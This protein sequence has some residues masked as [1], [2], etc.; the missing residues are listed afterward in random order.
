MENEDV[1]KLVELT[2]LQNFG[3]TEPVILK[4]SSSENR[5][6]TWIKSLWEYTP[7][8]EVFKHLPLL[9]NIVKGNWDDGTW[10]HGELHLY[11]LN[12]R[13][14]KKSSVGADDA[15][16][17]VCKAFEHLSVTVL[18]SLPTWVNTKT[19]CCVFYP[20]KCSLLNL[21]DAL[22]YTGHVDN[23]NRKIQNS[24]RKI[25]VDFLA[26]CSAMITER[27]ITL[28]HK[29]QLFEE[30][31]SMVSTDVKFVSLDENKKVA[32][33]PDDFPVAFPEPYL[34]ISSSNHHAL[35]KAL[36]AQIIHEKCVVKSVLQ[37]VRR[38][39]YG[40]SD[41]TKFMEW[42]CSNI[43]RFLQEK[44]LIC[45]A[46][47][48]GFVKC[49][50][51]DTLLK[52]SELFDP[53]E[54]KLKTLFYGVDVFPTVEFDMVALK[55]LGL[56]QVVD[57]TAKDILAIAT[58]LNQ[59]QQQG[60]VTEPF[61]EKAGAL[62][63]FLE[64]NTK[65]L[66]MPVDDT[67]VPLYSAISCLSC[68]P[69]IIKI[70]RGYPNFLPWKG[71]ETT[72]SSPVEVKCE[73]FSNCAGASITLIQFSSEKLGEIYKWNEAPKAAT[74]IAQLKAVVSVYNGERKPE[75]LPIVTEVYKFMA[76]EDSIMFECE[77]YKDLFKTSC[78]WWGDGFCHPAEIVIEKGDGDIDL[79]PYVRHLPTELWPY[80]MFLSKIGC[81][82][83]QGTEVFLDVQ[84][85]VMEK[86]NEEEKYKNEIGKD[87][88][89]IIRILERLHLEG[90]K[91]ERL[92]FP[93]HSDN[94]ETLIFKPVS[95][96]SY[97]DSK[98]LQDMAADEEENIYIVH[99]DVPQHVAEGLGVKSLRQHL[100]SDADP[101]G[102]WGQEEPL[103]RRLHSLLD[104]YRD[105]LSVPKELIQ[106][107]DDAGATKICF[108]YDEREHLEYRTHLL[109]QGMAD[110][111]G[112][113]LFVYNNARFSEE[114][115]KN[116]TKLNGGTKESDETKIGKFGL[117]FC[118]VY[119]LTDVPS[120][121]SGHDFV[122][123]DP[124]KSHLGRA[125]CGNSPGLRINLRSLKNMKMLKRLHDQFKPFDG[126]LGCD[127]SQKS[128]FFD[129]TLFRF[130]LR[131]TASEIKKECYTRDE[132]VRLIDKF[133]ASI[134]D[135]LLFTQTIESI[136]IFHIPATC[137]DP[138]DAVLMSSAEREIKE[139]NVNATVLQM[140]SDKK[141]KGLLEKQPFRS[142]QRSRIKVKI[143]A[144]QNNEGIDEYSE[145]NWLVSW[146]TGM[147]ESLR[148]C[149]S[150]KQKGALPLGAV[151]ILVNENEAFISVSS[152][153]DAP[154]GF[155]KT[156][157][158]FCYLPLPK[159]TLFSAHINGSFAVSSDRRELRTNNED[160]TSA[161][162]T[163]WN[164][165]IMSDAVVQA[166]INLLVSMHEP[167]GKSHKLSTDYKFYQL[168]PVAEDP[169]T[170]KLKSGFY[171][172][173]V[174]YNSPVFKCE[175]N[176][177]GLQSC[178]FLEK[179]LAYDEEIGRAAVS[180]LKKFCSTRNQYVID[181]P[182]EYFEEIENVSGWND[183]CQ[184]VTIKEFFGKFF[185][186]NINSTYWTTESTVQS[187]NK[188][189]LYCICLSDN[190]LDKCLMSIECV[191]TIPHGRKRKPVDL[192]HLGGKVSQLFSPE[193]ERFSEEVFQTPTTIVKLLKLGMMKDT[194]DD[195]VLI[196]RANTVSKLASDE[197]LQDA[198]QRCKHILEYLKICNEINTSVKQQLQEIP[199][200]PVQAKPR[201]WPFC[202]KA[203]HDSSHILLEK[204]VNLFRSKCKELVGCQK[205]VLNESD[206]HH[207][208]N[209]FSMLGVKTKA[210][211]L[212]DTVL[213]QLLL[214]CLD[215]N[216]QLD[217][218][219]ECDRVIG[220][221]FQFLEKSVKEIPDARIR[222][223]SDLSDKP[224]LFLG[225]RFVHASNVA[226][227]MG[228][229]CTPEL[230]AVEQSK[231]DRYPNFL[232]ALGVEEHFAIGTVVKVI[233]EKHVQFCEIPLSDQA[234]KLIC[235]LL[236][237]LTDRMVQTGMT[238]EDLLSYGKDNIVAPDSD[239]ILRP[240]DQLCFDDCE[241]VSTSSLMKFVH[242]DLSRT[243]SERLG[244]FTKRRKC[245]E[246]CS[247][248]IPFEQ[249]E[250][251][252]TRLRGL[253]DGYPC[254][255]GIMK[256]LI[257]NADDA[258]ATDI[259]FM[260]D[261]RTHGCKRIF[262]ESFS[263]FQGPA[264]C[265]YNDSSFSKADLL[266]I[267]NLGA[268]SKSADPCKT[269]QYGVG[270][271]AVYNLT[272][273]PS[274]LTK[275]PDIEGGETLCIFDPLHKHCKRKVGVR[276][277]NMQ[278][279]RST[280]SDVVSGYNEA[281]LFAERQYGTVFRLPLRQT[282]SGI[283]D[284][285]ITRETLTEVLEEFQSEM[286]E[287]MLFL[288]SVSTITVSDITSGQ[289][290]ILYSVTT[291]LTDRD[292][293]ERSKFIA[294]RSEVG[295]NLKT[296]E[297]N[298]LSIEPFEAKYEMHTKDNNDREENWFVVQ[299]MGFLT[300]NFSEDI[301]KAVDKRKIGLLPQGGVAVQV[302]A[303]RKKTSEKPGHS[304]SERFNGRAYCFLPLP[305]RTGMPMHVN[306]HFVLDHEAR[307]SL[308]KED[309]GFKSDWNLLLLS[310]VVAASY[311]EALKFVQQK[312]SL[313]QR[314]SKQANVFQTIR[315]LEMFFPDLDETSEKYWKHLVK[316]IFETVVTNHEKL[317]P[318]VVKITKAELVWHAFHENGHKFSVLFTGDDS[319]F[320]TANPLHNRL[321]SLGMKISST[322]KAV[323]RTIKGAGC[324]Y[325]ILTP[326]AVV[327]FLKS[328]DCAEPDKVRLDTIPC[329]VD[330]TAYGTVAYVVKVLNYCSDDTRFE[331][332]LQSLPLLVT[333]DGVLRC[334]DTGQKVFCSEFCDLLKNSTD[335]FV[336]S[337][338][339][340]AIQA[341]GVNL[342]CG[343]V[344]DLYLGDFA[345]LL[346]GEDSKFQ[347]MNQDFVPWSPKDSSVPDQ[348]WITRFWIF[349]TRAFRMLNN[350]QTFIEYLSPIVDLC[351]LPAVQDERDNILMK[352][353]AMSSVIH[354]ETFKGLP[355]LYNALEH[356]GIPRL[357]LN[358]ISRRSLEPIS[359]CL[360]SVTNP[361]LLLKCLNRFR[362]RLSG[363]PLQSSDCQAI[364]Q[365]FSDNWLNMQT[366]EAFIRIK[367]Y[368]CSLP[369]FMTKSGG[370][371]SL[372]GAGQTFF[373]LPKTVP[374]S[375]LNEWCQRTN[376]VLIEDIGLNELY[377]FLGLTYPDPVTVYL[378]Y[379]LKNF[380]SLPD[381]AIP[382]HLIYIRDTVL[383]KGP[384][385]I[386][387]SK[388]NR[389]IEML[390][391]TKVIPENNTRKKAS[392]YF[393][394]HQPV[395]AVMCEQKKFPP[396]RFHKK[397][398]KYFMELIGMVKMVSG[399]MFV[400]FAKSVALEGKNKMTLSSKTKSK[401]LVQHLLAQSNFTEAVL[402][403]ISVIRFVEPHVIKLEYRKVH[404]Q[405]VDTDYFICFSKSISHRHE[406]LTWS[407]LPLLPYWADP[408]QNKW[409]YEEHL[410]II[411][412]PT[413]DS[414]ISH[415]QN[416]CDSFKE[417]F[418]HKK[419]KKETG[420]WVNSFMEKL[421]ES[422]WTNC[423]SNENAQ[424]R[425]CYTPIVFIPDSE[426]FV[427]ATQVVEELS[428]G[429][430][431]KPYLLKAPRYYGKYFSLFRYLGATEYASFVHYV[432]VLSIV[433]QRVK[434]SHLDYQ[435]LE[436]WGIICKAIDNM[437]KCL[438]ERPNE[439]PNED[440]ILYL[441]TREKQLKDASQVVI[442]DSRNFE[443]RIGEERLQKMR[444]FIGF[445]ALELS[446]LTD[447][448]FQ[449]LP[450][451]LR[452][453][454]LSEIVEE[455][456]EK[457]DIKI[458]PDSPI[459]IKLENFL[460]STY[461]IEG[462][463]RLIRHGSGDRQVVLTEKERDSF[464]TRLQHTE[465]RQVIGLKTC[466]YINND[467]IEDS[468]Q[469]RKCY[470]PEPEIRNGIE[471][472]CIYFQKD[473]SKSENKSEDECLGSIDR[474]LVKMINR[475][476]PRKIRE[477]SLIVK[478]LQMLNNP[479][480][481]SDMLDEQNI[482]AYELPS[483]ARVSVFPDPGTYVPN[484]LHHLL[485]CEFTAFEEH[486]YR[487]V[488]LELED[489]EI[490][491]NEKV[492]DSYNP[493]YIFVQILRKITMDDKTSDNNSDDDI[494]NVTQLYEVFTGRETVTVP[495]FKLYKLIKSDSDDESRDL[496]DTSTVPDTD[497][498]DKV[499][500]NV[501][502][503][504]RAA[505][506]RPE[507]ERRHI[508]KR[509]YLR[510][511]P[512]KNA[513][514]EEFCTKVFQYIKEVIFKLEN[515]LPLDDE[516]STDGNSHDRPS[517]SGFRYYTRRRAYTDFT[518][519]AYFE[520]CE[521]LNRRCKTQRTNA[522]R[523][524]AYEG[525][526]YSGGRSRRRWRGWRAFFSY[527]C[528]RSQ[529]VPD[530]GEAMRWIS[531]A[532]VDL[533]HAKET[534]DVQG[535]PAAYNWI[536]YLCHQVISL[537]HLL[538]NDF[539]LYQPERI[540]C[541]R[542]STSQ[543]TWT[544]KITLAS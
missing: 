389:I 64:E 432:R 89:L 205:F 394:P 93:I 505:W 499:F 512:D 148:L 52:P 333:N 112:P 515:G 185:L 467:R 182:S 138:S 532:K 321:K 474:S 498:L 460:R 26:E 341:I 403:E 484:E 199:F 439:T 317:F 124:H 483:S 77:N 263:E 518:S 270:F 475:I 36:G 521:R 225:N 165:G 200:L 179:G 107:A 82:Q 101:F 447:D 268:G 406:E 337:D 167:E 502:H 364:L 88:Q 374:L 315:T 240:T 493:V 158:I 95:Q 328:Y 273:M 482:K 106:N 431:I 156:G 226:F 391:D 523:F 358:C 336:H 201:S 127:F 286:F 203:R 23:F 463:L 256:E 519:S 360:V 214:I 87:L 299:R 304:A 352:T 396:G 500:Y 244:V 430:E 140:C 131:T 120:F 94:E 308:W 257:Q 71:S 476:T 49:A 236:H 258:N 122:I 368:L 342:F 359:S 215:N 59:Q 425:L 104:G 320:S 490:L 496:V 114:D 172:T 285:V 96:C 412:N 254:D 347:S 458:L 233:H 76:D 251:L 494:A 517:T 232:K 421:Y 433:Q 22:E 444:I 488:A 68:I 513:G 90:I 16:E 408:I 325:R 190:D 370:H 526:S 220:Y 218:Q 480:G 363:R 422:L 11:K 335:Q 248:E 390:R 78:V 420:D 28:L 345:R 340:Q 153:T 47:N 184:V 377:N 192:V 27:K 393:S 151:A 361:L 306:G 503:T 12:N 83:K 438:K 44:E 209:V 195:S 186:P 434:D 239:K 295:A 133:K 448:S 481:I 485:S 230:Y 400:Q 284:V 204:P 459:A 343:V 376:T 323:Q 542:N 241:F 453:K 399:G 378:L 397:E 129:G 69:H 344:K 456:F 311:I 81:H 223:A 176:W 45:E 206:L 380:E 249:K 449:L 56:K 470:I 40:N 489:A 216:T 381:S 211:I 541:T 119:N 424:Q 253:L 373:M 46:Q 84:K 18:P 279:F 202:W 235:N 255:A 309:K 155:Y 310:D 514:N 348:N 401:V 150:S 113:A 198:F 332:K 128:P 25:F 234:F 442:C 79:Q 533:R 118:A 379:I 356:L 207:C 217:V 350:H 58:V 222:V 369:V 181:I 349:V 54:R 362:D 534:I 290:E 63:Q 530:H 193:D 386:Y 443:G 91:D 108:I 53:R 415:C 166:F 324:P 465:V 398:W 102:E 24:E 278:T 331:H 130:P 346:E 538:I 154:V 375:G 272:D 10:E 125:L 159:E 464:T 528:N 353:G 531:Q 98:W 152:L 170:N 35:A 366:E 171:Q 237:Y 6:A 187:R 174:R 136:Q 300:G 110:L 313:S 462:L 14:L 86:Y 511:H 51:P 157:H 520:F 472:R 109:D 395:F 322:S 271:N 191:P 410:G 144:N 540:Q 261:F 387:D 441:P 262:E 39:V 55:E 535:N 72:L 19:L 385:E 17:S 282:T 189:L 287:I 544:L 329:P 123:F 491:D 469:V 508:I 210:D 416:V 524:Y 99:G 288:K 38:G 3:S 314:N 543:S 404:K 66:M 161:D 137:T 388:Q 212:L 428:S 62:F 497:S 42:F 280:F 146:A 194:L 274:F 178:T 169:A 213:E 121:I 269:G 468:D 43:E 510:W 461:F 436:H 454:N 61:L 7:D 334:F 536:C 382:D 365:Y 188:L 418:K 260:I 384:S 516:D 37:A 173:I 142:L 419:K 479:R 117:G 105:G 307:R 283:S 265:V 355:G 33:V 250:E 103:T 31:S 100:M 445:D 275:G 477:Q 357:N 495:A 245:I 473:D 32:H 354:L 292:R 5:F 197:R 407:S 134:G 41:L 228:W 97:I 506:K 413:Q 537:I 437:F 281:T 302:P 149:Y 522:E 9:P 525:D 478:V 435:N 48:I 29:L 417:I 276:Y 180:M 529:V 450:E 297:V 13:F 326:E 70:P 111:Q 330:K 224:V 409:Y 196:E 501:L 164:E 147:S 75:L 65:L 139:N 231:I 80:R 367:D 229:D 291:S 85:S 318:V 243:C 21:L 294:R 429:Q 492:S 219:M 414:I 135:M 316:S 116:I 405:Y 2:I 145:S 527:S 509:L 1:V 177:F 160:D 455:I 208:S 312:L 50:K 221:I 73:S 319:G 4:F 305:E 426:D 457:S 162:D 466:L 301:Q 289:L 339:V 371:V 327:D 293:T 298:V 277:T 423:M 303:R 427:P 338:L 141:T 486:E 57:L 227:V 30:K 504:L 163:N 267:Q 266:G 92:F 246:E 126:V 471:Y 383:N 143:A 372:N 34:I 392:E 402:Q 446:Y 242:D 74:L 411:H 175:G 507:D 351:L 452:P 539:S 487:C 238:Y 115:L 259:H 296:G 451:S 183:A 60:Q 440:T 132:M 67:E 168:W 247:Q 8:Y 252:V 264:L 20:T 15:P